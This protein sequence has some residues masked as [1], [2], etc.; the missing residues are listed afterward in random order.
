[1]NYFIS[2]FLEIKTTSRGFGVFTKLDVCADVIIEHSPFSSCWSSKWE[3]TPENLRKVVFSH[4]QNTDNYVIGLGYT[5]IYNHNDENNAVW[6]T[7]D[8]GILI[9]TIR[10]MKAG[11]EVFIHYGDAYWSGGWSKY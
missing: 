11:E 10:N 2:S 8:N 3:D 6:S 1:M 7:S 9:K 4:P 5:A